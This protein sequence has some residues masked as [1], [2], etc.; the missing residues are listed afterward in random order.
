[1]GVSKIM[2]TITIL[3]YLF[4]CLYGVDSQI[5]Y[6]IFSTRDCKFFKNLITIYL[7]FCVAFVFYM[8]Q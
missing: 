4:G 5:A 7:M 3:L 2:F 1:M 8:Y 6:A